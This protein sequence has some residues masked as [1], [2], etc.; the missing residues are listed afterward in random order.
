MTSHDSMFPTHPVS[1]GLNGQ[2]DLPS[3]LVTVVLHKQVSLALYTHTHIDTE[4][5]KVL[6]R[7]HQHGVDVQAAID[8]GEV[9]QVLRT[10]VG[11]GH[12]GAVQQGHYIIRQLQTTVSMRLL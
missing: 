10:H 4:L 7:A 9:H 3:P 5:R 2:P 11:V 1:V 12:L 6:I 8:W